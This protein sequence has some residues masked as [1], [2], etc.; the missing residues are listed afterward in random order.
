MGLLAASYGVFAYSVAPLIWGHFERQ[1]GLAAL[2]MV[3]Q[4]P[5]GIPGDPLNIGL[6]GTQDEVLCAMNAAGWL[7]ADPTSLK[8]SL[9][10]IGS[11]LLRQS[12]AQAPVSALLYQGRPEDLAFEKPSGKSPSTR[13][14]VRFWK[15]LDTGGDGRPF[16]LGGATYDAGVGISHFTGQVTHHIGADI[17]AERD[18]LSAD[19]AAAGK[20]AQAYKVSGVGPTLDG[21][22]GGGDR[23]FTD[24][25]VQVAELPAGCQAKAA[26]PVV[27]SDSAAVI[28]KNWIW[29]WLLE[30]MGVDRPNEAPPA[31]SPPV[32][33]ADATP[34]PVIPT[35]APKAP[36][37]AASAAP[38]LSAS[39]PPADHPAT[40]QAASAPAQ[41]APIPTPPNV[42]AKPAPSPAPSGADKAPL[43]TRTPGEPIKPQPSPAASDA[44]S[45]ARDAK[46]P[47]PSPSTSAPFSSAP[48]AV[49]RQTPSA[50]VGPTPSA[51][52]QAPTR[53]SEASPPARQPPV[54]SA[55]PI[56]SQAASPPSPSVAPRP[57]QEAI[58]KRETPP[59]QIDA[60]PRQPPVPLSAAPGAPDQTQIAP[61]ARKRRY[62]APLAP[63]RAPAPQRAVKTAQQFTPAPPIP[64]MRTA[65]RAPPPPARQW[66]PATIAAMPAAPV[67]A[68]RLRQAYRAPLTQRRQTLAP[69]TPWPAQ[70]Q[71]LSPAPWA[72]VRICVR[73]DAVEGEDSLVERFGETLHYPLKR[74]VI[75]SLQS[76]DYAAKSNRPFWR[77]TGQG[78]RRC[79]N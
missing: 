73:R 69:P 21:R 8:N 23:Y 49:A 36:E 4:T 44:Q 34:A 56:V 3:T 2:P 40:T 16:W 50:S 18:L 35:S 76:E 59:P 17:D 11:V 52:E 5:Q 54:A 78:W 29:R 20:A 38:S 51:A 66:R 9:K 64:A 75:R 10:I 41:A 19:L 62:V 15:A 71:V 28:A 22:N 57:A 27:E 26:A 53:L 12:Y 58:S 24:G 47:S 45:A 79:Q 6:A 67:E 43:S 46:A 13:H 31:A 39:R 65:E 48:P 1:K 72:G 33:A 32:A 68:R 70:N 74:V 77:R 63:D 55:P 61:Q 25:D 14:H 30:T 42:S 7:P 60:T 37:V